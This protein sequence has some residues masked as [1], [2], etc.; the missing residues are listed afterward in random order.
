MVLSRRAD[1][2]GLGV[3][4]ADKDSYLEDMRTDYMRKAQENNE[5]GWLP[6]YARIQKA[7]TS[8]RGNEKGG[9]SEPVST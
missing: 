4:A 3:K 5:L 1:H 2:L 7:K 6:S 8:S 9:D